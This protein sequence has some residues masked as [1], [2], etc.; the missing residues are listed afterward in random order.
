MPRKFVIIG[1]TGLIGKKLVE[2]LRRLGH[3]VIAAA[4]SSGVDT[5]TGKGLAET[6]A[7]PDVSST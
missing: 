4:P 3:E 5:V 2:I 1:G 6:L 7:G